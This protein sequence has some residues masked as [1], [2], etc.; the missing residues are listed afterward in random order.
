MG[1]NIA[2][3]FFFKWEKI[4]QNKERIARFC[5]QWEKI[6]QNKERT[7]HRIFFNGKNFPRIRRNQ[8]LVLKMGRRVSQNKERTEHRI[9]NGRQISQ[10]N[11]TKDFFFNRRKIAEKQSEGFFL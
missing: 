4:S 11:R 9:S 2:F 3:S 8:T 6:S 10:N 5:F 1:G 7:E